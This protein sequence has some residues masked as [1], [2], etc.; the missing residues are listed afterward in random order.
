MF[1]SCKDKC[2]DVDCPTNKV[3]ALSFRIEDPV[4]HQDIFY[5]NNPL[6]E[7]DNF[8]IFVIENDDT[9]YYPVM[10]DETDSTFGFVF[11][12]EKS[13]IFFQVSE[14][15]IDTIKIDF[16]VTSPYNSTCCPNEKTMTDI[17]YN[18]TPFSPYINGTVLY[19]HL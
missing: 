4:S 12:G 11:I 6:Y 3:Y 19:K 14:N 8:K 10:K 9:L 16:Y 5:S 1:S 15:D 7:K 2:K 17:Y 18:E 13:P